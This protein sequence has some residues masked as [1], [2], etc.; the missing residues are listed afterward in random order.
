MKTKRFLL[1]LLSVFSFWPSASV[2]G[3]TTT[4][5]LVSN[6]GFETGDFTSWTLSGAT[7]ITNRGYVNYATIVDNGSAWGILPHAG[8]AAAYL[9]TFG[10]PGYLSQTLSTAPEMAYMLTI[11]FW[12]NNSLGDQ[13]VFVASFNGTNIFAQTNLVANGWVN[14]QTNINIIGPTNGNSVL[15][16][17]FED[18]EDALGL[19]DVSV[20]F[21]VSPPP[22]PTNLLAVAGYEQVA[23]SWAPSAGA[24]LYFVKRSTTSGAETNVAILY[25]TNY[26]DTGLADSTKYY[27]V[28]TAANLYVGGTS[29]EVSATTLP[30]PPPYTYTTNNGAITITGYT[31]SG[32]AVTIPNTINGLPVT[33]IGSGAFQNCAS[34]T[35]VT[36][37]A[38]VTN[39]ADTAFQNCDSL[40]GV[41]FLGNAPSLGGPNVFSGD[42]NAI[43][44]NAA[45]TTGWGLTFGGLTMVLA[46]NTSINGTNHYAYGANLGWLD[47]R[48]DTIHGAVIGT[49]IC[50]G[51]I[52][53]ANVGWINLGSGTPVNGLHYQNNSASD[54]G[55]NVDGSGNMSGYAY[56]A[57][58]GWITFEQTYGQPKVNLA[59]GNLSGSVW[60]ANCGWISL[61]NAVAYV[62]TAALQQSSPPGTPQLTSIS[63]NGTTLTIQAVNGT[64]SG[65]YVLLGTTNVALPLSQWTPILTN[66]FSSGGILNL[67]TNIIN[68]AV[69]QQFYMLE[70]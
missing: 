55:V 36:I 47:W 19:D 57:N 60:S 20:S 42:N 51:Y 53:S 28:V 25:A 52:Y 7:S 66:N 38:S 5:N 46:N 8:S 43:G 26:T 65:Q 67:S 21:V 34:L 61:S 32:G 64:A 35:S 31:G 50:S 13:N 3:Q 58:I 27:Y 10:A 63:V 56:G 30:P 44:Y 40:F 62:Q 59:T 33:A 45:G 69:P 23:L 2:K 22:A 68:P 54:F 6:G 29:S 15:Q 70:Q 9:A 18:D 16:F 37:P 14:I 1:V 12:V 11:S 39:I 24:T 4:N 17:M 49:N 48:S 41:Y